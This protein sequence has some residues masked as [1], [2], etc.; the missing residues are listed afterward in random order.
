MPETIDHGL[1][2]R[3]QRGAEHLDRDEVN[4]DMR[5]LYAE[6]KEAGFDVTMFRMML[7]EYR[8]DSD[9]RTS[10]YQSQEKYRIKAGLLA[11]IGPL[12]EAAVER[13]EREAA[14][15]GHEYP[16]HRWAEKPQ[17]FAE[18]T[19]HDPERP[20]GRGRPK[21][22]DAAIEAARAHIGTNG[23]QFDA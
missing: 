20:R 7:K 21:K 17:P 18:Q 13:E 12:G 15:A 8:M 19:V 2:E 23:P 3:L 14:A 11:S 4:A 5:E 22:I 6:V 10:L 16:S 9:A 1:T